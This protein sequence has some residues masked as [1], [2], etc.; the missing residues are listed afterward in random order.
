MNKT[1]ETMTD[2]ELGLELNTHWNLFNRER[3]IIEL[4]TKELEQ[5]KLR[6]DNVEKELDENGKD[7]S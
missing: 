5:R 6:H 4:I 3:V 1:I 7:K 2:A